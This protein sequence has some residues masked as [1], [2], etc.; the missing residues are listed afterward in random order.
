LRVPQPALAQHL[1][2]RGTAPLVKGGGPL[3]IPG[4][5]ESGPID[6]LRGPP[7]VQ[8]LPQQSMQR[9]PQPPFIDPSLRNFA[10]VE[11]QRLGPGSSAVS[12]DATAK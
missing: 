7:G 5:V 6:I 8:R 12:F 9:F 11:T 2:L 10:P 3:L 4:I 1:A